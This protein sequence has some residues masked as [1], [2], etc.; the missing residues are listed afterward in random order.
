VVHENDGNAGL[1]LQARYVVGPA[2]A[3]FRCLDFDGDQ[4][5]DLAVVVGVPPA[6]LNKRLVVA[7][8]LSVTAGVEAEVGAPSVPEALRLHGS[9]PFVDAAR[10]AFSTAQRGNVRLAIYD[11]SGRQVAILVDGDLTAGSDG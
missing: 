2:P 7:R 8:G 9:N 5:T 11:V 10:F 3:D 4:R 1:T 6:N